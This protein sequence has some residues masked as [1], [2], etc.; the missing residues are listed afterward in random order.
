MGAGSTF[1][2]MLP[3]LPDALPARERPQDELAKGAGR[4][5]VMDDED[6][7]REAACEMVRRLGYA[8]DEAADGEEAIRR[9]QE[10]LATDN[11]FTAKPYRLR[12]LAAA[13]KQ[14]LDS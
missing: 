1:T 10:A 8:A 2:V 5:L 14:A 13:L 4:V 11:P 9:Y 6:E 3:A 12:D 7:V